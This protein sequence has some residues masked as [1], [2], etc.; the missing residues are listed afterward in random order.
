MVGQED[1]SGVLPV[2]YKYQHFILEKEKGK[3]VYYYKILLF[4]LT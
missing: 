2:Y 1:M 3:A 4:H